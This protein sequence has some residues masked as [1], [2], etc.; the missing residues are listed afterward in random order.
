MG[1]WLKMCFAK[2]RIVKPSGKFD[3]QYITISY[4]NFDCFADLSVYKLNSYFQTVR[5]KQK[6]S[7]IW[8]VIF[9]EPKYVKYIFHFF[10]S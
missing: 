6:S 8:I 5:Q 7:F 9:L 10:P 4:A 1:V 3:T 2:Y